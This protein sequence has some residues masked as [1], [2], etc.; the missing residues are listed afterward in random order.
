MDVDKKMKRKTLHSIPAE[1]MTRAMLRLPKEILL[2]KYF[3]ASR[4]LIEK[5][6]LHIATEDM[7]FTNL[8]AKTFRYSGDVDFH[9]RRV[10]KVDSSNPGNAKGMIEV[11]FRLRFLKRINFSGCTVVGDNYLKVI[12]TTCAAL[13]ELNLSRCQHITDKGILEVAAKLRGLKR[14]F[15]EGCFNIGDISLMAIT[16]DCADME[17]IYLAYSKNITDKGM[18]KFVTNLPG[19]KTIWITYCKNVGNETLKAVGN[20]SKRLEIIGVE[21]CKKV[22]NSGVQSALVG[23]LKLQQ[24]CTYATNVTKP[25]IANATETFRNVRIHSDFEF[26]IQMDSIKKEKFW[27]RK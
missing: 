2:W 19:M 12:S 4:I 15:L 26:D 16:K 27:S 11:A 7:E 25:F 5:T 9:D 1:L 10:K 17:E 20:Y 23:C 21:G 8:V 6:L 3:M 14:I 22:S 18:T 24:V 13:E